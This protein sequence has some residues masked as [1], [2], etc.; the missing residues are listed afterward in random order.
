VAP[1]PQETI[2]PEKIA[3]LW[4]W[5]TGPN[6]QHFVFREVGDQI[7]GM[8][9]GP[10]DDPS[11]FGPLDNFRISGETMTFDIVHEDWGFGIE[12]GPFLNHATV[13]LSNHEM[14]LQTL[15]ELPTGN[16]IEIEMIL[17]GPIRVD[18]D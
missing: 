7:L 4:V 8:V 9:C 16:D 1:G 17:H 6:K 10:C 13:T 11:T 5:G 14:R 12:Y 2:R 18:I 3:G 15:Q